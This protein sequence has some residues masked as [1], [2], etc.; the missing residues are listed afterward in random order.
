MKTLFVIIFTVSLLANATA[1]P[2]SP[3]EVKIPTRHEDSLAADVYIP[4]PQQERPTIL[5]QTPYNKYFYRFGLPLN[6]GIAIDQSP[7]NFVIVDWRGF[8]ASASAYNPDAKEGE[9]GYDMVDWIIE[10]EWS[11]GQIGTCGSSALGKIQFLTA[12]EQHPNHICAVPL[13]ASPEYNYQMYFPNGVYREEYVEQLDALGYGMSTILEAHPYHDL[14]WMVAESTSYKPDLIEIPML[15]IGGW[16]DHATIWILKY[17]QGMLDESPPDIG[18]QHKLLMGPWAHGHPGIQAV[19]TSNQGELEFPEAEGESDDYARAFIDYYLLDAENGWENNPVIRY[20]QMSDMTWHNITAWPPSETTEQDFYLQADG[21][22]AT[23]IPANTDSCSS[24]LYDPRDPSPSIGG[25]TLH[26]DLDQ[27]PYNQAPVVESRDDILIFDSGT[28]TEAVRM[29]GKAVA[30]LY[31]S[32]N[33]LDTDF[34][35]RLCDVYPDGR[36][37]LL[38][39]GIYRMRFRNGFS[40]NVEE[41]MIPGNIY[42]IEIEFPDVAQ[43]FPAGHHI[44]LDITSSN[45]PRF[46]NN[47]NDGGE[48]YTTG[49]TINALNKVHHREAYPSRLMLPVSDATEAQQTQITD[50]RIYPNPVRAGYALHI[51]A[52]GLQAVKI[53]SP[54]GS[55][56]FRKQCHS[57]QIIIRPKLAKGMYIVEL[58]T[59][60][61]VVAKKLL[62]R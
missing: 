59:V 13:V 39:D 19:G 36:S 47:M 44:R 52:N 24:F 35:V 28:L 38:A 18:E 49:D 17:F 62:G 45:Y 23:T 61:G 32:S 57:D 25:P 22:L 54:D 43:T 46:N 8:Y 58:H 16:Y 21:S 42:E 53:Y 9:D 10:Q 5:I 41:M 56:L 29:A 51:N 55:C 34:A 6:I 31:V 1:Q 4:V 60:N 12:E 2:L 14:T 15:M 33:R 30:N 20:Y 50:C 3:T 11:D 26:E 40:E 48:M 27:G 37:M 7:Y